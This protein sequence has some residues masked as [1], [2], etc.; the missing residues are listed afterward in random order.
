MRACYNLH[1]RVDHALDNLDSPATST[2]SVDI[3]ISLSTIDGGANACLTHV[4][5]FVEGIRATSFL[6]FLFFSLSLSR[7]LSHSAFHHD[8]LRIYALVSIARELK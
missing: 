6:F 4:S 1:G 3:V 5:S 8:N 7:P 2:S